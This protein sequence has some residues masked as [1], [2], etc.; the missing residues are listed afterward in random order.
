MQV[1]IDM[2]T[3]MSGRKFEIACEAAAVIACASSILKYPTEVAG[4]NGDEVVNYHLM[5]VN[6]D[7]ITIP[8]N[9]AGAATPMAGAV[10]HATRRIIELKKKTRKRYAYQFYIC[11]G[12]PNYSGEGIDSVADT[13]KAVQEARAKGIKAFGIIIADPETKARMEEDYRRIFG[14][15]WYVVVE[16]AEK[17]LNPLMRFMRRVAFINR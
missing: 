17:I 9:G 16:S 10:R 1:K 12:E 13:A 8:A 6:G 2:S 4:F 5:P 11:D 15:G 14:G 7:R 3:S